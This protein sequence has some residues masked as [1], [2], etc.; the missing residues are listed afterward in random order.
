MWNVLE[1]LDWIVFVLVLGL[2]FAAVIW[3]YFLKKKSKKLELLDH[4]L[5][6]RKLSLPFFVA[7]LVATWYGDIFAVTQ[8]AF[9]QGIYM[10]ITQGVFWY[11]TYFIF[12]FFLVKRIRSSEAV[13]L[14]H[15][16]EKKFGKRS[17]KLA[18]F[19]NFFSVIP[20]SFALSLG[21]FL[22]LFFGGDLLLWIP[23]GLIGVLAY[24]LFGG[25][26]AVVFSDLI[27]FFVMCSSVLL[28]AALSI[29]TFGGL[30]FLQANLP[31]EHFTVLG[32]GSLSAFLVWGFLA[33]A[34]LVDP[35]FY[36]R[37][38]AAKSSATA[39]RGILIS[40]AIWVV[41]DLCT[42]TG[43]LYARAVMPEAASAQ[44]YLAYALELMPAGLRGF[45]VAGVLATILSSLDSFAFVASTTLTH[46]IAPR[47]WR[48][49]KSAYLISLIAVYAISC[50]MALAFDGNIR[51]VW[52]TLASYSSACLLFPVLFGLAF[53][54]RITDFK[55]AGAIVMGLICTTYGGFGPRPQFMM[56][57]DQFY[58]GLAGSMGF[59]VL[60]VIF[61][62][63]RPMKTSY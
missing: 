38:F 39:K 47:R 17:A 9:E 35:N 27:Q 8:I 30:S 13:T 23:C 16:V 12:A 19:L 7:T 55:F 18:A 32:G 29:G 57:L 36:H 6:G 10:F 51:E 33:L 41:F 46:D 53:P 4:L 56:E 34:T 52:K 28:I 2:T 44:A 62:Q 58:F 49:R 63:A 26:R 1:T 21:L 60:S 22:Q 31:A 25:F 24:S 54:G 59:L 50:L 3:G 48:S 42:T 37:C 14:P 43:A 11:L 61:T 20:V 45:V 15:L 5:M 40:I